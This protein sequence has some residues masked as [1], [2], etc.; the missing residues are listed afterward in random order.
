MKK[1]FWIELII[2]WIVIVPIG[3]IFVS[4]VPTLTTNGSYELRFIFSCTLFCSFIV[5]YCTLRI[6]SMIRKLV[7]SK[8]EN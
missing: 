1:D 5:W 6:Q 2:G 8:T 3:F 7:D 4:Y